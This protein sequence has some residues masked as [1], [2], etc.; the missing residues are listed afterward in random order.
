MNLIS[1]KCIFA[2]MLITVVVIGFGSCNLKG[3]KE[4]DATE[5]VIVDTTLVEEIVDT[6]KQ[7]ENILKEDTIKK[8]TDSKKIVTPKSLTVLIQN[9]E[10]AT[11]PIYVS[12]YGVKSKFPSPKGQLKEYKFVPNS[13]AYT[14]KIPN[15]KFGTYAIAM[16][17]D[18]NSNGKIDKNFIGIP[19][20]GFGFSN[21]YKP[22]VKAP[23]FKDCKFVYS[24][25]SNSITVSMIR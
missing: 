8:K 22:K 19:T 25:K 1:T 17:Q 15:L 14:V 12:V 16:Y 6:V 7:V 3:G 10:S 24:E 20:E 21:N 5:D 18:E 23:D 11:A 2:S 9:L 13:K 4:T